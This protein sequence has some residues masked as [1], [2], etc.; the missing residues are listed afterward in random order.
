MATTDQFIP[1][2][3]FIV[4]PASVKL[5]EQ[6]SLTSIDVFFKSKPVP[7]GN[8]SGIIEPAPDTLN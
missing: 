7:I 6:V 3:T 1:A 5:A 4:D 2:Q 8:Q